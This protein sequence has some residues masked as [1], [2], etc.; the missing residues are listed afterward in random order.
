MTAAARILEI[1]QGELTQTIAGA[2]KRSFGQER[3]GVKRLAIIANTNTRTAENWLRGNNTPDALH[4][5]RLI[6][7]VPELQAEVRR[8]AGMESDLDP[9]LERE[10]SAVVTRFQRMSARREA[11]SQEG[12]SPS[13]R[14]GQALARQRD[15]GSPG[16]AGP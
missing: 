9:E 16:G 14:S 4:L 11:P 1:G 6:A 13:T 12:A 3:A 10:L 8:L 15:R 7:Q 2:L 5:L